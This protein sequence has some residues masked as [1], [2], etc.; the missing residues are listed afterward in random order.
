MFIR[1]GYKVTRYR[2]REG[3]EANWSSLIS[4]G[5]YA[6]QENN[7]TCMG[8]PVTLIVEGFI[9]RTERIVRMFV[10]KL[11]PYKF[12]VKVR[13]LKRPRQRIKYSKLNTN[14]QNQ[15]SMVLIVDRKSRKQRDNW[16]ERGERKIQNNALRFYT[17]F[18]P[19]RIAITVILSFLKSSLQLT[20]LRAGKNTMADDINSEYFCRLLWNAKLF[21]HHTN[22]IGFVLKRLKITREKQNRNQLKTLQLTSG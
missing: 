14:T 16:P 10:T 11:Y 15:T 6:K 8:T 17:V 2:L 18:L 7:L 1:T 21:G 4:N 20:S 9:R 12:N 5:I 22:D 19:N 13:G 3:Y